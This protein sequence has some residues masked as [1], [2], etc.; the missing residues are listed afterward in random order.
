[1]IKSVNIAIIY[2]VLLFACSTVEKKGDQITSDKTKQVQIQVLESIDFLKIE[3][4]AEIPLETTEE[5]LIGE[6]SKIIFHG[7]SIFVLDSRYGKKIYCFS[8]E[9]KFLFS[10]GKV[11]EAGDEYEVPTDFLIKDDQIIVVDNQS[12]SVLRY[13]LQGNFLEKERITRVIYEFENH[14]SGDYIAYAPTDFALRESLEEYPAHT[15]QVLESSSLEQIAGWFPY[16]EIF[17]DAPVQNVIERYERHSRYV[18]PIYAHI[19]TI[20]SKLNVSKSYQLDLKGYSWPLD[21][22]QFAKTPPEELAEL[23]LSGGILTFFHNIQEDEN[24][25]YLNALS[26]E[27]ERVPDRLD[28]TETIWFVLIDKQTSEGFAARRITVDNLPDGYRFPITRTKD[29]FVSLI[30]DDQENFEAVENPTLFIHRLE[31]QNVNVSNTGLR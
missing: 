19:H 12:I 20:D 6:I 25:I 2:F 22:D 11:G 4:I 15:L 3:I 27:G 8:R 7:D 14:S 9:G 28:G 17:D 10:F 29:A 31:R 30:V 16:Q 24:Y 1:M 23:F 13:D 21:W 26:Q 5:S 18:H